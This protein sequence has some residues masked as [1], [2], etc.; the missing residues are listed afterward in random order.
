MPESP[1]RPPLTPLARRWVRIGG[2]LGAT[3]VAAGAFGA[4]ALRETLSPRD[5]EIYHTAVHY[6][7]LHAL[8]LVGCGLLLQTGWQRVAA[9]AQAFAWGTLIFSG[10]LY[11]LVLA[12]LRWLG[13][14][15][16]I[17]GVA[18]VVGWI[19]LAL[20]RPAEP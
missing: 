11:T 3:G 20:A 9:S 17:G 10:S 14:V 16:P 8:A 4:H 13:A 15:T 6:Q 18:L 7:M 12:D 1:S 19:A 2:I 5:L